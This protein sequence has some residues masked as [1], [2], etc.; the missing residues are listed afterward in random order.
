MSFVLKLLEVS[1]LK[2]MYKLLYTNCKMSINIIFTNI[3]TI[4]LFASIYNILMVSE[5]LYLE[6]NDTCT[7]RY[8][9]PVSTFYITKNSQKSC[10]LNDDLKDVK[11]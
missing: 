11:M 6:D 5:I 4:E 8:Q 9:Q 1:H 2:N 10:T 3:N 7:R